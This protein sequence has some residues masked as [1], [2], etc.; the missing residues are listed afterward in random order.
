MRLDQSFVSFAV[1]RFPKTV[2]T[3]SKSCDKNLFEGK[4]FSKVLA[5]LPISPFQKYFYPSK[6]KKNP[7]IFPFQSI[8]IHSERSKLRRQ[9]GVC[10]LRTTHE[11][12]GNNRRTWIVI[13]HVPSPNLCSEPIG[14]PTKII[15]REKQLHNQSENSIA[16]WLVMRFHHF[17]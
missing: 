3:L 16:Y 9:K 5:E 17:M 6:S 7:P 8:D 12:D 11:L 2:F 4:Y 10:N 15:E 13:V 14:Q 1:H